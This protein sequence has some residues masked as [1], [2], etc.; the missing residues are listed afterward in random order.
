MAEIVRCGR[1]NTP[2]GINAAPGTVVPCP[3]CEFPVQSPISQTRSPDPSALPFA[4]LIAGPA[5]QAIPLPAKIAIGAASLVGIIIV[6]TVFTWQSSP[7]DM[8]NQNAEQGSEEQKAKLKKA[9]QGSEKQMAKLKNSKAGW[10]NP[11]DG[12]VRSGDVELTISR[13]HEGVSQILDQFSNGVSN[14]YDTMQIHFTV[15]NVSEVRLVDYTGFVVNRNRP[16]LKDNFG[17]SY[18]QLIAPGGI[19]FFNGYNDREQTVGLE[20]IHPQKTHMDFLVFEKPIQTIRFLYLEMPSSAWGRPGV[21]KI[22]IPSDFIKR[23]K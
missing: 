17:N 9:E 3:V 6:A 5:H 23:Q 18:N 8:G 10:H 13:A 21:V 14:A 20:R 16:Q 15:K 22:E 1:C 2:V 19:G 7:P 4:T 12:S 11:H